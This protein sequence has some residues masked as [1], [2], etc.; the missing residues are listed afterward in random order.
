MTDKELQEWE[1]ENKDAERT[2]K[3]I[4]KYLLIGTIITVLAYVMGIIADL[5][6]TP[7]K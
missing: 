5:I 7:W 6:T 3:K 1:E 4:V 2:I